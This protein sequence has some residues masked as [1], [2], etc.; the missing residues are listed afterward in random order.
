MKRKRVEDL[1]S[2]AVVAVKETAPIGLAMVEMEVAGIRHLPVIDE[3]HRVVGI[4]SNRDVMQ[5][6]SAAE[7]TPKDAKRSVIVADIMSRKLRV[8]RP[9]MPAHEAA[10]MMLEHKIGALPVVDGGGRL[11]AVLTETDFLLVAERALREAWAQ[12]RGEGRDAEM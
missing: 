4:L 10:R 11:L 5:A 1:M 9:R 3:N 6:L 12:G 2:T 8:A 7:A